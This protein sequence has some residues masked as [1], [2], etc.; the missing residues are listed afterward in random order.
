MR[1]LIKLIFFDFYLRE[2]DARE[3]MSQYLKDLLVDKKI[4]DSNDKEYRINNVDCNYA[5]ID[6]KSQFFSVDVYLDN[7]SADE[8]FLYD[9]YVFEENLSK[10]ISFN[11]S[12]SESGMQGE[13][14]INLDVMRDS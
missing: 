12:Y 14:H 1:D 2:Q 10:K 4:K 6:K 3:A 9:D 13:K 5:S 11:S 8:Y 7:Y